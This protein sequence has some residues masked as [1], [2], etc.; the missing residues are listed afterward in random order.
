MEQELEVG[1]ATVTHSCVLM[2]EA[3]RELALG[4]T[5]KPFLGC[6]LPEWCKD[7]EK[8]KSGWQGKTL[9]G[10]AENCNNDQ[11]VLFELQTKR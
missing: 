10:N 4:C 11:N 5:G 8:R 1:C 2:C 7:P 6:R 3:E 9:P